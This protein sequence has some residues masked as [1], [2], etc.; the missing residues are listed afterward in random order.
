MTFS[1][2]QKATG[3]IALGVVGAMVA[4]LAVSP[5]FSSLP[6]MQ[7]QST[8]PP[9]DYFPLR[10]DDWWKYKNITGNGQT[11]EF[12][13]TVIGTT[14]QGDGSI[15][16]NTETKTS[17]Q[18]FQDWYSKPAGLVIWHKQFYPNNNQDVTFSPQRVSLK[19]PP[20]TG[21]TWQWQGKGMMGVDIEETLRVTGTEEIIV[22][23]GKFA[24][25]KVVAD[26]VQG[27]ATVE[28]RIWFA[29][30][31]GPV[32]IQTISPSFESTSELIDYS[33]KR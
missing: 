11:S 7:A 18:S 16:F 15:W 30:H 2:W 26:V 27:G 24:T 12:Q 8:P 21:D 29:N 9:P 32:K 6:L 5:G 13:I 28:R 3:A 1:G 25:M 4:S 19:N 20:K 23:A 14:P 33:F 31:V 17:F 22:P 10:V